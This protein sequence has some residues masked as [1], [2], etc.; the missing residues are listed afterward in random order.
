MNSY[1]SNESFINGPELSENVNKNI[2]FPN[3][4]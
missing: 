2:N 4:F 3:Y 1:C